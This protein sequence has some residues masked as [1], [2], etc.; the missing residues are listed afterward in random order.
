MKESPWVDAPEPEDDEEILPGWTW[1]QHRSMSKTLDELELSDEQV[2]EARKALDA[3]LI[4]AGLMTDP[5]AAKPQVCKECGQPDFR[6][7]DEECS[8]RPARPEEIPKRDAHGYT[9]LDANFVPMHT[10]SA[11]CNDEEALE[12]FGIVKNFRYTTDVQVK[13]IQKRAL[14]EHEYKMMPYWYELETGKVWHFDDR[15]PSL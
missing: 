4:E 15:K 8:F 12:Y 7:H 5:E 11:P 6:P 9:Y 10:T 14:G 1:G 13:Y 2:A 3:K